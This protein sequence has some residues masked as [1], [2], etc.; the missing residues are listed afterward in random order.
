M[1]NTSTDEGNMPQ[2]VYKHDDQ[3]GFSDLDDSQESL[4][5][6]VHVTYVTPTPGA[7]YACM[8]ILVCV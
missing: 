6:L 1:K 7:L 2:K 8:P 4:L 3:D 5:C